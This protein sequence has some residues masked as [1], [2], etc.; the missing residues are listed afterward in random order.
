MCAYDAP[1]VIIGAGIGGLT[2]ALLLRRRGIAAEVLEQAVEPREVGAAVGLAANATRVLADLG[3]ADG[4]ARASTEPSRL[5]HRDGRDGRP[6]CVTGG[7]GWYRATFGAPFYNLHRAALQRLL[8]GA[9]GPEHVHLG[10]HATGL[11]EAPRGC[12]CAAPR[13]RCSTRAWW[14][15]PTACIRWSGPG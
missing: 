12:G 1:V 13:A 15:A 9:V 10:C 8:T 6:V 2:L 3:L 4:L 5:I 11:E 7:P 14:W